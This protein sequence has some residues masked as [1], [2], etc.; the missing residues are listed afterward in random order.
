MP[1]DGLTDAAKSQDSPPTQ[2]HLTEVPPTRPT[3]ER[4]QGEKVVNEVSGA[5]V[6]RNPEASISSW[7][8]PQQHN[9]GGKLYMQNRNTVR[10]LLF[11]Y[12]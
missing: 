5:A 10:F 11:I 12:F 8:M 9:E 1:A 6:Y 4:L 2:A 7:L 3:P